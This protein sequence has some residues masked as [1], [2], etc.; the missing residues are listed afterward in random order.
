MNVPALFRQ[1]ALC[2]LA[3][4]LLLSACS[5]SP[6][7]SAS[8]PPVSPPPASQPEP[9]PEPEPLPEPDPIPDPEPAPEPDDADFVLVSDCIPG[10]C[11][12]LAYATEEN[13]TGQV[14][15]DFQDAW[16]RH[17]TVKKLAAAAEELAPMGYRLLIWDAFR[18]AQAQFKLW[19][20]CPDARYVA[21]PTRGFSSHS[22]GGTVDLTLADAEGVP[23]EMPSGFDDFSALAD[24]D[25]GDVSD[26]AAANARLLE[27]VMARCGFRGYSAEWWH[28]SDTDSYPV[29]EDFCPPA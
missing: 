27:D 3:A 2:A 9:V 6:A 10:L 7:G 1:T 16:L 23:V 18:P 15:Y 13:F 25:Y 17:G 8:G 14:I 28:Y 26:Q 22:R 21:N 5:S 11:V 29:E 20:A 24:R 19:D 4:L 12:S